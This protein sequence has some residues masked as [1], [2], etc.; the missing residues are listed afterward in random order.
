MTLF[1]T[2]WKPL[3][4]SK[5][6]SCDLFLVSHFLMRTL[7]LSHS[8]TEENLFVSNYLQDLMHP[9]TPPC[10]WS[11]AHWSQQELL[12]NSERFGTASN[13]TKLAYT[14]SA[15]NLVLKSACITQIKFQGYVAHLSKITMHF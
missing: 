13:V 15:E 2:T 9:L 6:L 12:I 11:K 4:Y 5:I 1:Y 14:V 8:I 3:P 10:A 7:K